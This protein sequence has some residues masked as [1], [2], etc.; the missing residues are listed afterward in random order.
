MR[1]GTKIAILAGVGIFS[2]GLTELA[3]VSTGMVEL[4]DLIM[5]LVAV[6]VESRTGDMVIMLEIGT[7]SILIVMVVQAHLSLMRVYVTSMVTFS[8]AGLGFEGIDIE[9]EVI[10]KGEVKLILM[11]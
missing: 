2:V 10:S 1:E 4:F 3:L 8:E 6:A 9:A 7:S 5:R 11:M